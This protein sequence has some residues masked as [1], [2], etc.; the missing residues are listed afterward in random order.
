MRRVLLCDNN[1]IESCIKDLWD[2]EYVGNIS[3]INLVKRSF[4]RD[5]HAKRVLILYIRDE[6]SIDNDMLRKIIT[7]FK[8]RVIVFSKHHNLDDI[9]CKHWLHV[10]SSD[11]DDVFIL[12]LKNELD[13]DH[14]Y[15]SYIQ[16]LKLNKPKLHCSGSFPLET[17]LF[18]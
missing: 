12:K 5:I 6:N 10:S 8:A 9:S 17:K 16:S 13:T 4:H 1:E 7:N 2:L 18:N 3:D 11:T 14:T 15:K